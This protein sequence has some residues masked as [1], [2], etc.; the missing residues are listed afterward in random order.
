MNELMWLEKALHAHIKRSGAMQV[1]NV[2][3][4]RIVRA[5]QA[6]QAQQ[7]ARTEAAANAAFSDDAKWG[8]S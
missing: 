2:E 8:A 5:A 1:T 4:L 7:E 6:A 3:L